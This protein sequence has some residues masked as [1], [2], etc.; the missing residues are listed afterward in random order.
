MLYRVLVPL[1]PSL[2]G[3]KDIM[4]FGIPRY[5]SVAQAI[6]NVVDTKG[7]PL[8]LPDAAT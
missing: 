8:A 7:R 5:C 4:L 2:G 6:D 1:G 3:P